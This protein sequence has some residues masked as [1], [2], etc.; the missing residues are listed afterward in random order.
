MYSVERAVRD[1]LRRR[2]SEIQRLSFQ[3]R[4]FDVG[5]TVQSTREGKSD[6]IAF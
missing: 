6:K 3:L 2:L 1:C 5:I 4:W